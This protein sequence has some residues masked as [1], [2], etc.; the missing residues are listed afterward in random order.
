MANERLRACIAASAGGDQEH[1]RELYEHLVDRVFAY[2]RSRTNTREQATDTTQDVFIELWKSLPRFTYHSRE[3]FYSYVYVIAKRR[4][5]ALYG[6]KQTEALPEEEILEGEE[7]RPGDETSDAIMRALATL[8]EET[9]EIITLHHWLR[10]TFKEIGDFIGM[11]ETAVR[12]RH[13]RALKLL[14]ARLSNASYE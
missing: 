2:V 12:V 7:A 8:D 1:Y 3:Q 4:L 9:R 11:G 13:H 10:Y 6:A 5:A 14:Q